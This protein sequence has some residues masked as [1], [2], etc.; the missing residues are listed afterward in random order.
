LI[1]IS[2]L[3]P[4][5]IPV[6]EPACPPVVSE[7]TLTPVTEPTEGSVAIGVMLKPL[8]VPPVVSV[9]LDRSRLMPFSV[10]VVLAAWLMVPVVI[11]RPLAFILLPA[12][13]EVAFAT[14]SEAP[15][16][17]IVPA[18]VVVCKAPA[19]ARLSPFMV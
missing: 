12:K 6:E 4:T 17:L 15:F 10:R 1:P 8:R 3:A 19:V 9:L 14:A 5:A 11:F 7:P 13:V 18:A 2:Q 16:Q